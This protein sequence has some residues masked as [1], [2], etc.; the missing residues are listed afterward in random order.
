MVV[1]W[2]SHKVIGRRHLCSEPCSPAESAFELRADGL[3][4]RQCHS[5]IE[6]IRDE[7]VPEDFRH[8]VW[9]E[10]TTECLLNESEVVLD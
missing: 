6:K 4:R 7:V 8:L 9:K 3:D 1:R 5:P 2:H 10:S